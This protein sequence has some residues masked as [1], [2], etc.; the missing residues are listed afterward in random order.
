MD[1]RRVAIGFGTRGAGVVVLLGIVVGSVIG[2]DEWADAL[3]TH[4]S[5][6]SATV[7]P[8]PEQTTPPRL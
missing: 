3:A 5:S 6:A 1:L 8:S 7:S 4:G 2:L